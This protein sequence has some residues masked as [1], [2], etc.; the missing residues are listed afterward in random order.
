[1]RLNI[2]ASLHSIYS[3]QIEW[4]VVLKCLIALCF[5][6]FSFLML[7]YTKHVT[8]SVR[9]HVISAVSGNPSTYCNKNTPNDLNIFY[10]P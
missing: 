9:I 2:Y 8:H 4:H 1:M 3:N 5:K 7:C 6:L 10:F